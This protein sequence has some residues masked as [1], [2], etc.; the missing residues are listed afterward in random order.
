[1]KLY[2]AS[3]W[4]NPHQQSVVLHLRHRGHEV[5]DFMHPPGGEHLGFSWSDVDLRW[6]EW[7]PAEYLK[8]LEHPV[9]EAGFQSDWT[10]MVWA[11]A[12]VLVLPCGRSAHLE[13]GYFAGANKPLIILLDPAEFEGGANHS[14]IELMYKMA[15]K[16]VTSTKEVLDLLTPHLGE[17]T[18]MYGCNDPV[19]CGFPHPGCGHCHWARA[20][21]QG[22]SLA[23]ATTAVD[24]RGG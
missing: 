13:A 3:S 20:E 11:E 1:M 4:R 15:T 14:N 10:A 6:P 16:V 7:S 24:L 9:A 5:Y 18:C 2:V 8:G 23:E 22:L 21:A 19:A 12:C 17:T